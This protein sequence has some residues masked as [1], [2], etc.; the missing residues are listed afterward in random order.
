LNDDRWHDYICQYRNKEVCT[1]RRVNIISIARTLHLL[2]VFARVPGKVEIVEHI[3][4]R[5]S[6]KGNAT[7]RAV[8][9]V[10]NDFF[11][12]QTIKWQWCEAICTD[13]GA[14]MTGRHSG[15]VSWVKKENNSL[16]FINV[17]PIGKPWR[18]RN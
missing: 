3:L 12:E 9:E 15:L 4:F 14:A 17:S 16:I 13:G 1:I 2:V 8:F 6:L 7:G 11:N 10:I 5:K 18:Q